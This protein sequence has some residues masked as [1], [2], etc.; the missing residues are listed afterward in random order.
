MPASP[1]WFPRPAPAACGTSANGSS[2]WRPGD[3]VEAAFLGGV[4]LDRLGAKRIA[5]YFA[6]NAV[7][8]GCPPRLAPVHGRAGTGR[9]S[10]RCP[11]VIGADLPTLVEASLRRSHPDLAILVGR[12]VEVARIAALIYEQD[13]AIR[14][15]AA[16]GALDQLPAL[17]E[18]AGAAADSLYLTSFWL[19]DTTDS[20][21]RDFIQ[22]VPPRHPGREP[23][24]FEAM[25]YDAVMILAEAIREVGPDRA[26]I[27]D[28]LRSLGGSRP[29]YRGVTGD[30]TFRS[31]ARH[32]LYL[33]RLRDG[34]PVAVPGL[35]GLA[36]THAGSRGPP[37][38]AP[39]P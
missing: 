1:W 23:I 7:R 8:R 38:L 30:I 28:W 15:L 29:A 12:Q 11:F 39:S 14:L 3:S 9:W 33:V 10:T 35:G 17:I 22:P 5:I 27:R 13:P 25:R 26:A 34:A 32:R 31:G 19:P 20:L 4:A 2:R 16:D 21:Q 24:S 37:P 18:T 6:N 36:M